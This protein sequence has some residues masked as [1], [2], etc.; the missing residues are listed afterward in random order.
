MENTINLK[1]ELLLFEQDKDITLE[2]LISIC[3]DKLKEMNC[4]DEDTIIKA[5]NMMLLVHKSKK[6]INC[7]LSYAKK[8]NTQFLTIEEKIYNIATLAYL[9]MNYNDITLKLKEENIDLLVNC[10]SQSNDEYY[11]FIINTI[12]N[13]NILNII[14]RIYSDNKNRVILMH[15]IIDDLIDFKDY[16]PKIQK[17][18]L[19]NWFESK[20]FVKEKDENKV[21]KFKKNR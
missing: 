15:T 10:L 9:I 18:A 4:Q 12:G 17:Q 2:N 13:N 16:G 21:L 5:G 7:F 1:K 20:I 14:R 6:E 8:I 3:F 19:N 11:D